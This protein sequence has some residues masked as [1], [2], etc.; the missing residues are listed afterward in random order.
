MRGRGIAVAFWLALRRV[1]SVEGGIRAVMTIL[2]AGAVTAARAAVEYD[3]TGGNFTS[4]T[5]PYTTADR[6]TG[7]IILPNPLP[8]SKKSHPPACRSLRKNR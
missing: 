4:A 2:A 3:F 1:A 5:A 6:V 8:P 7:T